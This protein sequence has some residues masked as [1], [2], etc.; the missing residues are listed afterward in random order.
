[1]PAGEGAVP[2]DN[3]GTVLVAALYGDRYID[4]YFT[5]PFYDSGIRGVPSSWWADQRGP[6][7][8]EVRPGDDKITV[9][10]RTNRRINVDYQPWANYQ[11]QVVQFS[12]ET[13][14]ETGRYNFQT[15]KFEALLPPRGLTWNDDGYTADFIAGNTAAFEREYGIAVS[16]I[17]KDYNDA[18]SAFNWVLDPLSSSAGSQSGKSPS[19]ILATEGIDKLTGQKKSRDVF[20][21]S[22]PPNIGSQVDSIINF[23]YKNKD[24][25]QISEEMFGITTGRFSVARKPK[26]LKK[27]LSKN[28]EVVYNQ[29]NGQLIL[30][31]NGSEPGY[32]EEGGVFAELVG[33]PKLIGDSVSFV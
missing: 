26:L 12:V 28:I 16:S 6:I 21:F 1:V 20:E 3:P 32:G 9:F 24:I 29:K 27:L 22:T 23:S 19:V 10:F 4:L 14:I 31:A 13:G 15:K 11:A 30:N 17:N 7:A 2:E 5:S 25:I 18:L 33:A 8:A